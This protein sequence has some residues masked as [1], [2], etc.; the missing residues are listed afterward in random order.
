MRKLTKNGIYEIL[1]NDFNHY[2]DAICLE[3]VSISE[4]KDRV[5]IWFKA[6]RKKFS[7][8]KNYIGNRLGYTG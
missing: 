8:H 2:I 3:N 4:M 6:G 7:V 5:Q 1:D